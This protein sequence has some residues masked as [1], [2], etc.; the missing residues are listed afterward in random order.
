M[1]CRSLLVLLCSFSFGHC[2]VRASIYGF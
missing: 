2:V 1:V